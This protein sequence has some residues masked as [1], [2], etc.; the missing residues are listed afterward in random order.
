MTTIFT[1]EFWIRSVRV[2]SQ[3][4]YSIDLRTETR[5]LAWF[6]K[7]K[8]NWRGVVIIIVFLWYTSHCIESVFIIS[9]IKPT[10]MK[11]WWVRDDYKCLLR[12]AERLNTALRVA[13][14]LKL[15]FNVFFFFFSICDIYFSSRPTLLAQSAGIGEKER[16][17]RPNKW[18]YLT[19]VP[20]DNAVRTC[21]IL[22][23]NLSTMIAIIIIFFFFVPSGPPRAI[24]WHRREREKTQTCQ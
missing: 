16:N 17:Q 5:K 10:R 3:V 9:E 22:F 20:N 21:Y 1:V 12:G 15:L 8:K 18:R 2:G 4:L 7:K 14:E 19:V 6:E 23:R 13:A 24:V 11:G